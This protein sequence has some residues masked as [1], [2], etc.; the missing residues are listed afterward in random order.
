MQRRDASIASKGRA[1]RFT[2][3]KGSRH[4][5]T[6]WMMVPGVP[7][8]LQF[9]IFFAR[10]RR[11][12]A[13][14]YGAGPLITGDYLEVEEAIAALHPELVLG[15]QMERHIARRLRIACAVISAP[16]HVQ[17]F[18]ARYSPVMGFG[19]ANGLF[20]TWVHP[21]VMGL[22]E[23]SLVMFRDDFEFDD[24]AGASHL[25]GHDAA[26]LAAPCL[27]PSLGG[28]GG[29]A[30]ITTAGDDASPAAPPRSR[31]G[32]AHDARIAANDL[33]FT[34]D[35]Q[36][37]LAKIPFFVRGNACRNTEEFASERG[38]AAINIETLYE[39]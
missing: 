13:T 26:A 9:L 14:D 28:A 19:G 3:A 39:A 8:P 18:P 4:N 25:G 12:A 7:T 20:D 33:T 27:L 37:E 29:G 23:H 32:E 34:P 35:A 6:V 36:K 2:P 1:C 22:E 16:A 31:R 24:A 15:T 21:L 5:A 10:D 30:A 17:D 38:L 11:D